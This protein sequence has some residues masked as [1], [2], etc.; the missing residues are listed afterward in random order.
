MLRVL[1]K[2]AAD[3]AEFARQKAAGR[4]AAARAEA[5]AE[6]FRAFLI[7]ARDRYAITRNAEAYKRALGE[8]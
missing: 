6:L 8:P 5:P 7:A 4:R 1:E 3:A 2:K